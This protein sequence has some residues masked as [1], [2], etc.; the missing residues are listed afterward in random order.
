M[1][2]TE[3]VDEDGAHDTITSLAGA[4][5]LQRYRRAISG[6]HKGSASSLNQQNRLEDLFLIEEDA[7]DVEEDILE[8]HEDQDKQVQPPMTAELFVPPDGGYGWLIAFGAFNALFWTAGMVKSYGVIFDLILKTFPESSVTL[9]AWIPASMTTLALAMAPLASALCQ[10]FNCRNVTFVGSLL[11]F[12]GISSSSLAQNVETLFATFGIC[13][14]LGIGLS[15][16]PGIILVARYFDKRR[17]VANAFCLSGTAAGSLCLPFLIKTLAQAYAFEGTLLLLGA[18]MLHISVSAALY[19]PLAVHVLITS[20]HKEVV[21]LHEATEENLQEQEWLLTRES[22][23]HQKQLRKLQNHCQHGHHHHHHHHHHYDP[24]DMVAKLQSKLSTLDAEIERD[25]RED[26]VSIHSS[27]SQKHFHGHHHGHHVHHGHSGHATP[28][29]I[30]RGTVSGQH[31]PLHHSGQQTP[32][33][34]MNLGHRHSL[35]SMAVSLPPGLD[36]YQAKEIYTPTNSSFTS[37]EDLQCNWHDLPRFDIGPPPELEEPLAASR[38]HHPSITSSSKVQTS[39]HNLSHLFMHQVEMKLN[40]Y[41]NLLIKNRS[42]T[43][44]RSNVASFLSVGSTASTSK[45]PGPSVS[46]QASIS[47]HGE[48]RQFQQQQSEGMLE[49]K[50]FCKFLLS[51]LSFYC[52]FKEICHPKKFIATFHT[53]FLF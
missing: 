41:K 53:E 15:T 10:R 21:N 33:K 5:M 4:K 25:R 7:K 14:G 24:D 32:V 12:I 16:T 38:L 13:T 2:D 11:C 18:C 6:S 22:Q 47:H 19:R 26:S 8:D 36:Y 46:R 37:R 3:D 40:Q 49:M 31:T 35:A 42:K 20:E 44:L 28:Q 9:A 39:N 30:Q 17:G 23:E 48:R 45:D 50:F 29:H 1:D 43:K 52:R 51:S 27:V 34:H